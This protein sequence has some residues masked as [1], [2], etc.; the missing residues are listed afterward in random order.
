MKTTYSTLLFST[1]TLA[2]TSCTPNNQ[3]GY[4]DIASPVSV[5]EI[6][7]SPISRFINTSGT[8]LA[9][10]EITLKSEMSGKYILQTNP[11]TGKPFKLGDK[12]Q[13]NQVIIRFEDQE[14][15]NS[16]AVESRKLNLTIAQQEQTKQKA[17]YEKGGVTLSEMRNTEV[18]VA[19]AKLSY[20]NALLK[21]ANMEL[22]AP[23]TGVIV[24]LPHYTQSTRIEAGNPMVTLMDYSNLFMEINLPENTLLYVRPGQKSNITHY[25]LPED[26]IQGHIREL[27]PAIN[28]ETRTYK[29]KLEIANNDLKIRPGMFVKADIMIERKDSAIVIPKRV[30]LSQGN[31]NK[32]VFV[33]DRNLAVRRDITT[34]IE[35]ENRVEI[36]DGLK[37]GDLLISKGFETLRNESKVKVEK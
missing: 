23:F 34:G 26:T 14:Y 18:K 30:I 36:I 24:D 20:E 28:R 29:G 9:T 2:I 32:Y 33:L 12:V 15:E 6:T 25:T 4:N 8:A 31:D 21:L 27:S 22:K 17:L 11:A 7:K 10:K 5:T 35:Q 16:Q 3:G 1:L 37:K 13:A 19:D